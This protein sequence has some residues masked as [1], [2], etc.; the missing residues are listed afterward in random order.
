MSLIK[1]KKTKVLLDRFI[2]YYMQNNV[3]KVQNSESKFTSSNKNTTW[4]AKFF[5]K[6]SKVKQKYIKSRI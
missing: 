3:I 5:N 2:G 1:V 4:L 6:N